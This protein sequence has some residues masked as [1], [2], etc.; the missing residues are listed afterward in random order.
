MTFCRVFRKNL[1]RI[2]CAANRERLYNACIWL[3]KIQF[4]NNFLKSKCQRFNW[5]ISRS[6]RLEVFF[7]RDVLDNFTKL[8]GNPLYWSLFLIKL[9]FS[10]LQV[11]LKNRLQQHR[12]FTMNFVEFSRTPCLLGFSL[13]QERFLIIQFFL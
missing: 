8:T 4:A 7:K 11:Y 6:R 12:R 2:S 10:I 9:Q 3:K 13:F 1:T 5:V